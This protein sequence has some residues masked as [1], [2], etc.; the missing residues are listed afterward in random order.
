MDCAVCSDLKAAVE[1]A[2][3]THFE[4]L[5]AL[6]APGCAEDPELQQAERS[7]KLA[8]ADAEFAL[9][10]HHRKAHQNSADNR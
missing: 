1:R 10:V 3:A 7:C 6:R 2:D 5:E 8:L 9:I 4:A